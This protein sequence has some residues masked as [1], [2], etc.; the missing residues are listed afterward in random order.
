LATQCDWQLIAIK[1]S[2]SVK[3]RH[4]DG[5]LTSY[6]EIRDR[7]YVLARQRNLRVDWVE[8][9]RRYRDVLLYDSRQVVVA[10]ATVPLR[11]IDQDDLT[12]LVY[13]LEGV[14]GKG[15]MD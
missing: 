3:F 5:M 13:D 1:K 9:M 2:R 4:R 15:W 6:P 11:H 12:K 14:F 7:I 8:S 10:R